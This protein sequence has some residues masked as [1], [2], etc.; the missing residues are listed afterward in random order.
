MQKSGFTWDN[1]IVFSL[2]AVMLLTKKIPAPVI[3]AIVI[4]AG[5]LINPL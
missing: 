1:L 5:F 2:T 4:T 3:V